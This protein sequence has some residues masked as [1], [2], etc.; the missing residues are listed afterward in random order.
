MTNYD[1]GLSEET[2]AVYRAARQALT[3]SGGKSCSD[4]QIADATGYDI[5]LV[6]ASL[7][8]LASEYLD[9][10]PRADGSIDVLSLSTD[11][12]VDIP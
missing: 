8:F 9:T 6:R 2:K 7:T 3:S 11:P 10:K 12:P 5:G 4:E 1:D